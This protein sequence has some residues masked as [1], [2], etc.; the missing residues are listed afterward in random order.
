MSYGTDYG[1][2]TDPPGWVWACDQKRRR[3]R[4]RVIGW[5]AAVSAARALGRVALRGGTEAELGEATALLIKAEDGLDAALNEL[6][7][8]AGFAL[9]RRPTGDAMSPEPMTQPATQPEPPDG[10]GGPL[11]EVDVHQALGLPHQ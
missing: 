6:A 3:S 2:P 11:D 4:D 8:V 1:P 10:L 7:E 9:V 5:A